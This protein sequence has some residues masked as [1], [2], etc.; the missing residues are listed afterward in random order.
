MSDLRALVIGIIGSIIGVY[1]I[2]GIERLLTQRTIRGRRRQIRQLTEELQLLEK[3]GVS[4]RTLLLFAF[5]M[6]FPMIVL[7][8]V[9]VAGWMA[10]S[11]LAQPPDDS[12]RLVFLLFPIITAL[13]ALSAARVF[14]KLED[15]EPTLAKLRQKLSDLQG[16]PNE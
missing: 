7:A 3:V 11:L 6:L 15:P 12:T 8:G 4:D 16:D 9:G 13:V 1:A 10:L 5:K 14:Q 2:R